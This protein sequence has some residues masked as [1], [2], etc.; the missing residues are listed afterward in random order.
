VRTGVT[1]RFFRPEGDARSLT[2]SLSNFLSLIYVMPNHLENIY[3]DLTLKLTV[4]IGDADRRS[5]RSDF[6]FVI[7][8][9][10]DFVSLP[11]VDEKLIGILEQAIQS[12]SL[13]SIL[14]Q[15]TI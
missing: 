6:S 7:A 2:V 14:L 3:L 13:L 1:V 9:E 12:R 4:D 5:S 10:H 8:L 15:K 11:V